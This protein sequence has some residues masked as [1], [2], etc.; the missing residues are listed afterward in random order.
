LKACDISAM[1]SCAAVAS[2]TPRLCACVRGLS[3]GGGCGGWWVAASGGST[4]CQAG[5][6]AC[7]RPDNGTDARSTAVQNHWHTRI[8]KTRKERHTD[9]THTHSVHL[10]V[11]LDLLR[12]VHAAELGA[13][14]AQG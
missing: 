7:T 1:P 9:E 5:H 12:D 11:G 14:P 4:R 10:G 2:S 3:V 8:V 13:A 6:A